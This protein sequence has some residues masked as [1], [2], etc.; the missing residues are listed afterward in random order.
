MTKRSKEEYDQDYEQR[1]AYWLPPR[2][3]VR[4]EVFWALVLAALFVLAYFIL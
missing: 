2:P 3:V 4:Q 1:K